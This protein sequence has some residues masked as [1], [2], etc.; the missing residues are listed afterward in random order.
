MNSPLNALV[1]LLMLSKVLSVMA[2]ALTPIQIQ[3]TG[4][5]F[6]ITLQPSHS[7]S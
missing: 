7:V 2:I 1:Y 4:S 5:P 3:K 6:K